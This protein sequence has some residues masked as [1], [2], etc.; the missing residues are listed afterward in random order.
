M[1]YRG[2]ARNDKVLLAR[3][4]SESMFNLAVGKLKDKSVN[5]FIQP[6][7]IQTLQCRIYSEG[8]RMLPEEQWSQITVLK[9]GKDNKG[10]YTTLYA[11]YERRLSDKVEPYD[12]KISLIADE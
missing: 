6:D 7:K 3:S 11:V 5:P 1:V 10:N 4:L 12:W 8:D 2:Y 9:K